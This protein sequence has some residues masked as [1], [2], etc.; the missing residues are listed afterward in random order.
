MYGAIITTLF[1]FVCFVLENAFSGLLGDWFK[2]NLLIILIVFF[3]LFRG[4]RYSILAALLA[5]LLKDSLGVKP[6]GINI[7]AFVACAYLTTYIKM[8]IYHVG[9]VASR[10]F[11][12]FVITTINVLILYILNMIFFPV[13]FTE[14]F[15]FILIPELA[16]TLLLTAYVFEKLKQC[17]LRLYA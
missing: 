1:V 3:N 12:V 6:F 5:G 8:Y 15:C 7:F 11:L 10:V 14:M 9:S 13:S 4:I 2:P 17:A 16:A